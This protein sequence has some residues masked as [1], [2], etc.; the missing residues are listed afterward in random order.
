MVKTSNSPLHV[1]MKLIGQILNSRKYRCHREF[2]DILMLFPDVLRS[3]GLDLSIANLGF[4]NFE[5]EANDTQSSIHSESS[6]HDRLLGQRSLHPQ[7]WRT[8]EMWCRTL[9]EKVTTHFL[10]IDGTVYAHVIDVE[11]S[12]KKITGLCSYRSKIYLT[13]RQCS[14]GS[15]IVFR[16]GCNVFTWASS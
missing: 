8:S 16:K 9:D 6:M 3:R 13:K 12:K 10:P 15:F 7:K 5:S 4:W 14:R 11:P 1:P 2:I